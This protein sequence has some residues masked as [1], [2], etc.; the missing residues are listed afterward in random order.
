MKEEENSLFVEDMSEKGKDGEVTQTP[1]PPRDERLPIEIGIDREDSP[2]SR[3]NEDPVPSK[4]RRIDEDTIPVPPGSNPSK[5]RTN[6]PF[7][8]DSDSEQDDGTTADVAVPEA[9]TDSTDCDE[10]IA[11]SAQLPDVT[12][13]DTDLQEDLPPRLKRENTSVGEVNEF[14]GIEDFID[15]EFPADG[16]EYM[17]RRWMEEQ[18]ELEMGLDDEDMVVS[19]ESPTTTQAPS[20]PTDIDPDGIDPSTCPIC[21]GSTAGMAEQVGKFD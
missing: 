19:N 9:R 4:R 17:E 10:V 8:D 15:D 6:G 3:F 14:D 1:T 18:A 5:A 11:T 7:A 21:G 13:I 20:K 2:N 16:E 12:A